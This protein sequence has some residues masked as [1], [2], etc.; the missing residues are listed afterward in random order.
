M[1]TFSV[2]SKG[3]RIST[4]I[5]VAGYIRE[6]TTNYKLFIP[7]DI[8]GICFE[9]WLIQVSDEWDKEFIADHIQINGQIAKWEKEKPACIYGKN[10]IESGWEFCAKS[11]FRS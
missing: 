7:H 8:S 5:L 3:E 1:S 10:G 4:D 6:V 11:Y 9:Y 2:D